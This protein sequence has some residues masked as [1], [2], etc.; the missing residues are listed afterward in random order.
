[1]AIPDYQSLMRPVLAAVSEHPS[2]V[3][4]L[5]DHMS[6][7][8]AL[9]PEEREQLLPSG[10]QRLIANRIHWS[11]FYLFRAGLLNRPRR[12]WVEIT[13]R[14]REALAR[15]PTRIDNQSLDQYP[16]FREFRERRPTPTS[17]DGVTAPTIIGRESDLTP[18]E[19]LRNAHAEMQRTLR[20]ELIERVLSAPPR[21]F[22][23]LVVELL[24]SM[25]YGGANPLAGQTLGRSG[26]NGVDGV[27]DQ[28][29]LGLD[30][31]YV[32]AKRYAR[33]VSVGSGEIRD[34][35]GSLDRFRA[36][37]G[38]FVTTSS[39]SKSARET[40]EH[41]S[42]RIVLIDGE[43][44]TDLMTRYNVGVRVEQTF[45]IKKVDEDFFL[46]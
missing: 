9:N 17:G 27:I 42:K 34:F 39:F 6:N 11:A 46:E 13:D 2:R 29:S 5:V 23:N 16:E 33:H 44:L 25:G 24:V 7:E 10:Q 36:A 37:K 35:F 28:D 21:F 41:L 14:G 45:P 1:M 15:F 3:A 26:D 32:Q 22:E 40:A 19:I 20:E 30:R 18:E 31:V 12:G 8:F 43:S 38:L 4:D